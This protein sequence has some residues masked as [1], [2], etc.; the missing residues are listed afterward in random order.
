M[1]PPVWKIEG[2]FAGVDP[3]I[4]ILATGMTA[5][6]ILVTALVARQ[7]QALQPKAPPPSQVQKASGEFDAWTEKPKAQ[8]EKDQEYYAL[9][10]SQPG[11]P[12]VAGRAPPA[13]PAPASVSPFG[14]VVVDLSGNA[15]P[16]DDGGWLAMPEEPRRASP[17]STAHLH[18]PARPKAGP[19]DEVIAPSHGR[20]VRD[21]ATGELPPRESARPPFEKSSLEPGAV[22]PS[23]PPG[24]PF[25]RR[26]TA[27]PPKAI[28]VTLPP[29]PAAPP[30]PDKLLAAR[31][32]EALP[33]TT[34]LQKPARTAFRGPS[35]G[36]SVVGAGTAGVQEGAILSPEKKSIRCPKCQ[37]VFV[38]PAA[39]PATVRCPACGTMGTLK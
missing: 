17:S 7:L 13:P 25:S 33:D 2:P 34:Q 12:A 20:R 15:P 18:P 27:P 21:T 26:A 35:R 23:P 14:P 28:S 24:D 6:V 19:S 22:A 8:A 37:T 9:Y 10:G 39:R 36:A 38:G 5:A 32:A 29:A 3:L 31:L 30:P 4:V 11:R 1:F 16:A